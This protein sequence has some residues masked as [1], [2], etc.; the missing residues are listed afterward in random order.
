VN[1]PFFFELSGEHK[2]MCSA[3]ALKCIEAETD[4]YNLIAEGPGYVV[5]SFDEE[6]LDDIADR[7]SLTHRIGR[8]LGSFNPDD[9]SGFNDITIPE[10]SFAVRGKRFE[11][12]MKNI[13]SQDLIRKLGGILSKKNDVDLKTPEQEVWMFMSDKIHVFLGQ[14]TINRD[15]LETR[16][17]GE[18]PFFSPISLHPRYARALINLTGVK[19]GSVVLDPFCGTGGIVIEAAFMGMKPIASDFDQEMIDGTRENMDFYDLELY[20]SDVLDVSRTFERFGEVDGIACDPPYGRS[21]HTGGEDIDS[22]YGRAMV[23][24]RETL[25]MDH[26]VGVVLPHEI[27]YGP[28]RK[29]CVHIQRVHGSLSRYYHIFRKTNDYMEQSG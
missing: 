28:M 6:H 22:I 15:I 24:F 12:K 3:E 11:G 25:K 16:K 9:L 19:R 13:D 29:E 10:G 26:T 21:T 20:D 27:S 5:A 8:H 7:I 17:V 18:R 23:S 1:S 4:S 2:T 14:R